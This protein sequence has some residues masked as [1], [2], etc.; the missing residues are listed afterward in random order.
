MQRSWSDSQAAF[1]AA[2]IDSSLPAPTGVIECGVTGQRAGFAVYRNNSIVG[3]VDALAARFP[4][5]ARLVGDEFF[6]AMARS[7]AVKHRPRSPLLMYYG[8][9]FPAF[10][11][12]F[13]PA[14]GVPYLS[15]VAR[16]EAAWS[17]AYHA[18]DGNALQ[19]QTLTKIAPDALLTMRL[20][21]HPSTRLL[22]SIY[23]VTEIWAAHQSVGAVI[24]PANWTAQDVLIVRPGARVTLHALGAGD[25]AFAS[26]LL[27]R[28]CAQ[29]AAEA[30]LA[31][32]SGFDA[33]ESI[34]N[35]FRTGAVVAFGADGAQETPS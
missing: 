17:E 23:P 2:I 6:R 11:D 26:A 34:V 35:L 9:D 4:V 33:G 13:A 27:I 5:T 24:P 14:D 8:D 19:P 29:D 32:N 20:T 3:L 18:P 21:L 7:Y 10:I 31:E 25:Y 12:A 28:M 16:L 22:R 15:D 1:A 30:A